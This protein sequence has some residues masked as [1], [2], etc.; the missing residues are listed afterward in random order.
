MSSVNVAS[1]FSSQPAVQGRCVTTRI[2]HTFEDQSWD[3]DNW[4][5]VLSSGDTNTIFLTPEYQRA[6]WELFGRGKLLMIV[7]QQEGEPVA[8][9]PLFADEGMIFFVGSGGSDYLDFVGDVSDCAVLDSILDT[10]RCCVPDFVGFRF[11][12]VPDSSATG[13]LLQKSAA[14][15]G[16]KCF[17]EGDLPAP[18]LE[19]VI[20]SEAQSAPTNKKS[21]RRHERSLRRDG[22]LSVEHSSSDEEIAPHLDEFFAQHIERWKDTGYPSLFHDPK[23]R[24]FYRR[25]TSRLGP[26]GRL[27]FTRLAWNGR[28]IAFHFGFC[29]R[30]DYLW[31]KPS[32]AID[33]ARW[34]PG[35]VLLR[36]LLLAAIDEGAETF[37]FG[38]GDEAF[39]SRFATQVNYVRT[40]GLY[41]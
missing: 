34:S 40:W 19:L 5:R 14:R 33:L 24:E 12:H 37:D 15:L 6:W 1:T 31:Y 29:Y 23:Q 8:L 17:D 7:A 21:L 30:G 38:L 39:K 13:T 41:P 36:H 27:R 11:Y 32:F 25:L 10:A 26:T 20:T 3:L 2:L 4:Q 22:Q 18:A 16:M 35:E 9:A 28:N